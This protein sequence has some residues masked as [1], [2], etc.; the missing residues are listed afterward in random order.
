MAV[1]IQR[2]ELHRGYIDFDQNEARNPRLHQLGSHPATPVE[3]QFWERSD[4]FKAFIRLNGVTEQFAMMSDVTAGGISSAIVDAK[5][6]LIAA[7]ADNAVARL[8]VGANGTFLKANSGQATG[9]Q[10]VALA[11]TDLSDFTTAA[12]ASISVTDGTELDFSYAAGAIS[13][14]LNIN[15]VGNNKIVQMAQGTIKGRAAGAGTGDQTDLTG[16]QVKTILAITPSDVSGF[17]T[18]VRTS[19]L[20]QMAAPTAS[21]SMNNNKITNLTDGTAV[22]DAA[23]YGQL[24][25]VIEGKRW[26]DTVDFASTANITIAS[27]GAGP[28][29][30]VTPAVGMRFL[31]KNQT[32]PAENGIYVYNGAATPATRSA[33]A[34]TAAE[35]TNATVI[36]DAGTAA[37][38]DV[39]TVTS[40]VT[41]LGTD[42]VTVT[43]TGE[44]NQTY[45][46]GTGLDLTGNVFSIAAAGVTETHLAASVAGNGLAGGAGTAL[47]VNVGTGLE[48]SADAVRI[49]AA[50]A[51]AG[52]TG[53][54]GSALA[55]GQGAGIIVSADDVAIDT[56]VVVRKYAAALTSGS[57]T[58]TVTHNLNTRD[59]TVAF[60][61]DSGTY[62]E[63]E[64]EI[65]HTTV[66][67]LTVVAATGQTIPTGYRVVV[68]G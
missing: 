10:W 20:D 26:K 1:L 23:T 9:L 41:T 67:A 17:D 64:F 57:N 6:D 28:F 5:G 33:D 21:V 25:A 62:V 29:D 8:A 68:H 66:N 37:Q 45:T 30:G 40:T 7:T 11:S 61:L 3:G 56:A 31:A 19:R 24:L 18:Q 63:T 32:A 49:A 14:A 16:A 44:G 38:G 65:Q 60:Y 12:R 35:I 36:V 15:S 13:A 2:D 22:G 39:Y 55:V 51:G 48:I 54:A 53:G 27:P 43:K 59:V 50:A 52:L 42:A 47:S 34:N 46:N 58:A 4:L